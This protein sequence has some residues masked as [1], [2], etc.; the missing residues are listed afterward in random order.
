MFAVGEAMAV[1]SQRATLG[2][3]QV[4]QI[5][6][7][8]WMTAED[9]RRSW[10]PWLR[11]TAFGFP[12]GALPA[13]G[14]EVPTFLSYS[15]EKRLTKHPEEFGNGAIEGVAGPEA[16]NNASAAGTLVPLLTLGIP[17]SAT[18]AIMLA[19]FQQYNLQPGP[20]LFV[21]SADIVWGLIASLFIANAMLI[22][23]NLPMIGI[24]V[25]L[26]SIPRPWLYGGILM[27]ATVGVLAA[28]GS[29][30]ELTLVLLLGLLAFGMRRFDYPIAPV[31][32]GMILGPMAETQLRR[33][34]Q[35]NNGD[36]MV[37][38][39]SP[40]SATLLAIAVVALFGPL[41][42]SWLGWKMKSDE[43]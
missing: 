21:T 28:K 35:I 1:A 27:F 13:G 7:S 6:G 12:I 14:A 31:V 41:L 34:L 10:L 30:V 23:L 22:V 33:A 42:W 36:P 32:V 39:H 40:I 3:G 17:T 24:W 15:V 5:R 16:A 19:G 8:L 18:A 38:L 29:L 26:L 9:W 11:G 43:D 2:E 25:K 20:L 37:L 4:E